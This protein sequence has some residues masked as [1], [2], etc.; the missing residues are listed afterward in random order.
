MRRLDAEQRASVIAR[1][2]LA[3]FVCAL[4]FASARCLTSCANT[5]APKPCPVLLE[6]QY[7]AELVAACK[8]AGSVEACGDAGAAI[9]ARHEAAQ[10]DA[11]CRDVK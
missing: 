1:A 8:D 2:C 6:S 3:L 11:G 9:T 4:L 10:E 5:P 7:T